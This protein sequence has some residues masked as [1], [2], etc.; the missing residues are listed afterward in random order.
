LAN[1]KDLPDPATAYRPN[2]TIEKEDEAIRTARNDNK[3]VY[4]TDASKQGDSA[5]GC[6]VVR[7]SEG[8]EEWETIYTGALHKDESV[9]RGE[10]HSIEAALKYILDNHQGGNDEKFTI[11][12]DSMSGL[13]SLKNIYTRDPLLR[14]I[15]RILSSLD[16]KDCKITLAWVPGHE[17]VE[18]N[19]LADSQAKLATQKTPVNNTKMWNKSSVKSAL[20]EQN[21]KDWQREWDWASTGRFTYSIIPKVTSHI[22]FHSFTNLSRK[23]RINLRQAVSGHFPCN[24]YLHRFK[25]ADSTNCRFCS[26][27]EESIVHLVLQCQRFEQKRQET[28]RNF[29]EGTEWSIKDFFSIRL[30]VQYSAMVLDETTKYKT[31]PCT[32]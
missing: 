22:A 10:L 17:G 1:L 24:K 5:I 14:N 8:E 7:K 6:A 11:Y 18:G 12:S 15:L 27:K 19:E 3:T 23:D 31:P 20:A 25:R 28:L 32:A 4:Y 13:I 29:P 26:H 2:I 21:L 16:E 9:Y 30:L